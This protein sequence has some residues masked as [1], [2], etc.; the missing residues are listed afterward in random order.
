[1]VGSC[2]AGHGGAGLVGVAVGHRERLLVLV[3]VERQH[4]GAPPLAEAP[5]LAAV[6]AA[7]GAL[8]G[9]RAARAVDAGVRGA[10][11]LLQEQHRALHALH[12]LIQLLQ[13]LVQL[14]KVTMQAL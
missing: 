5:G 7:V 2:P 14:W 6:A 4:G 13:D 10:Q 1:M 12:V 11:L 9:G 8:V 3:V